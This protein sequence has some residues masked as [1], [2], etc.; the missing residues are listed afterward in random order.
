[1]RKICNGCKNYGKCF[2]KKKKKGEVNEHK[3]KHK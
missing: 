2:P 3:S 1:M